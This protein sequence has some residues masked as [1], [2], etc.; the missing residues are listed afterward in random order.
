MMRKSQSATS[1][2]CGRT[3]LRCSTPTTLNSPLSTNATTNSILHCPPVETRLFSPS[4]GTT[5]PLPSTSLDIADTIPPRILIPVETNRH[6]PA[7][8]VDAIIGQP[9][10]CHRP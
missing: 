8:T 1:L 7:S 5:A 4:I 6:N 2:R 3:A 9:R 10:I